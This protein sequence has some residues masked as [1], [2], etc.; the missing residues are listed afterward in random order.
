MDGLKTISKKRRRPKAKE[1]NPL[2]KG[3]GVAGPFLLLPL[4]VLLVVGA[5]LGVWKLFVSTYYER[6]PT[7]T[8]HPRDITLRG[9][10]TL[11]RE[12]LLPNFGLTKEMNGFALMRDGD[13]VNKLL[14]SMPNLRRVQMVYTPRKGVEIWVDERQPLARVAGTELPP[15]VV[16]QEGVIFVYPRPGN[17]PVIGGF[18]L[19]DILTPGARLQDGLQC[20]LHLIAATNDPNYRL[21]SSV[22]KVSLLSLD[23]EDGLVVRLEDGRRIEIAWDGMGSEQRPSEGMYS[24][25][26]H[27]AKVMRAPVN[28]GKKRFNAMAG[29]RIAVSE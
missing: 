21:P 9:N 7:Y 16:D 13:I 1:P 29:D 20:M 4:V 5:A 17:Y 11:T 23:P 8:V 3:L 12:L 6:N 2:L 25:L 26:A 27:L 18:D 15:M 10:L 14:K 22:Q 19:P 28:A 24:R